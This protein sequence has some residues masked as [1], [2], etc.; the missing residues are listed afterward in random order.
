MLTY[1]LS[2]FILLTLLRLLKLCLLFSDE[3]EDFMSTGLL[4]G[5]RGTNDLEALRNSIFLSFFSSF[6]SVD[7]RCLVGLSY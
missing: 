1:F 2:L 3:D 5:V 7:D 6:V 4:C